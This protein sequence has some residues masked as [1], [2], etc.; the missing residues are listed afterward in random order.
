[1][2]KILN[3]AK[4]IVIF[5]LLLTVVPLGFVKGF[6][7]YLDYVGDAEIATLLNTTGDV[8]YKLCLDAAILSFVC[9]YIM[10]Y[11]IKKADN[12]KKRFKALLVA[13]SY[14]VLFFVWQFVLIS[15]LGHN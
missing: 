14:V 8:Y 5:I 3:Q 4:N 10:A 13:I 15:V 9:T 1:M 6:F 12:I 2:Q 11:F 7:A